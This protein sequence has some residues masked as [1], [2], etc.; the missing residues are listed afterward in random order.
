[1]AYRPDAQ[2]AEPSILY[3]TKRGLGW[4]GT[5]RRTQETN[6][7]KT[8]KNTSAKAR[9]GTEKVPVRGHQKGA[10]PPDDFGYRE[11]KA[12][13]RPSGV[14]SVH[15]GTRIAYPSSASPPGALTWTSQHIA[16]PLARQ[17]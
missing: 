11:R 7:N 8:W 1:M 14:R 15:K 6:E 10:F 13:I 2:H 4:G 12:H 16:H 3:S 5:S 9:Q 17:P